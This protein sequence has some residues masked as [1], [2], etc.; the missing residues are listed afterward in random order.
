[1]NLNFF[2]TKNY[3]IFSSYKKKIIVISLS[4]YLHLFF[5]LQRIYRETIERKH[6]KNVNLLYI[7]EETNTTNDAQRGYLTKRQDK[8][9]IV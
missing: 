8:G 2:P 9:R 1:M 3:Y 6:N 5:I 4:L 7:E